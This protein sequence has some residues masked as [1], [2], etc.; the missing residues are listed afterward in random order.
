MRGPELQDWE[1]TL[2]NALAAVDRELETRYGGDFPLRPNRP[3][4]GETA[5]FSAD[6]L[7][8]V[9]AKYTAGYGSA[10]GEGY[11]VEVRMSTLANV[12]SEVREELRDTA[13]Q[14]LQN[15]LREVFPDRELSVS[16]EGTVPTIHG[17]LDL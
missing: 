12:P 5:S 10:T 7:F 15:Q 8:S 1:R 4:A 6:G 14:L 16:R 2:R 3:V 11:I 13:A 9:G 17:A